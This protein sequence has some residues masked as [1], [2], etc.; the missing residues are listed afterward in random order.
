M[1]RN[2]DTSTQ[3]VNRTTFDTSFQHGTSGKGRSYV[4][5]CFF[6]SCF[7]ELGGPVGFNCQPAS[8]S[9]ILS[10]LASQVTSLPLPPKP[11]IF[12]M[13]HKD[14]LNFKKAH[15]MP[16]S[17]YFQTFSVGRLQSVG[18]RLPWSWLNWNSAA[19]LM[20]LQKVGERRSSLTYKCSSPA[21]VKVN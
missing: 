4:T 3:F 18:A 10:C 7:R 6:F 11:R 20:F 9:Q 2:N 19:D 12:V 15:N 8:V 21:P 13:R 1:Q 14:D 17:E 5:G 16:V